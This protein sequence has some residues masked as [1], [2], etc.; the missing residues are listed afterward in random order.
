N[1]AKLRLYAHADFHITVQGGNAHLLPMFPGGMVAILHRFG[2]EIRH[3]YRHG[4]FAY[5]SATRP[6]WLIC[7][8]AEELWLTVPLFRD[9]LLA[10]GQVLLPP[11]HAHTVRALSPAAQCGADRMLPPLAT[12]ATALTEQI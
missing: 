6:R 5:A 12:E 8:D 11:C 2:Q 4:P 1:E 10:D 3:S 7:R 9:A